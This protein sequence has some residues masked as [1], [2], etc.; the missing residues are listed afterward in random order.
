MGSK[1]G[2]HRD[3]ESELCVC[4]VC[5]AN[6]HKACSLGNHAGESRGVKKGGRGD[7]ICMKIQWGFVEEES[8]PVRWP[9]RLLHAINGPIWSF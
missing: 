4:P 9:S 5:L 2:I 3:Q 7:L 1:Q 6:I 8:E